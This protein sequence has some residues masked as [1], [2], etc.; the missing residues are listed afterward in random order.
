[1]PTIGLHLIRAPKGGR[2][3]FPKSTVNNIYA[4]VSGKARFTADGF[5]EAA[6]PG[7]VV[8]MPCWHKHAIEAAEDAVVFRVCDEPLL[9]KLG[10]VK[11]A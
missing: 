3:D 11:T 4:V 7:D 1:M 5:D 9:A 10:L 6:A 8:A 2:I